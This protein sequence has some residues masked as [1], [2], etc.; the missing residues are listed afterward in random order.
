MELPQKS[1]HDEDDLDLDHEKKDSGK[2][3][4]GDDTDS[5]DEYPV[6]VSM[7]STLECFVFLTF[8]TAW[9]LFI[10]LLT[11]VVYMITTY[12]VF[13]TEDEVSIKQT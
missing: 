9:E 7:D 6:R 5:E 12:E 1:G 4:I 13:F 3:E 10:V 2:L 11:I 8:T